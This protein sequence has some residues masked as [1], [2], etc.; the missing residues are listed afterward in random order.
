MI[1]NRTASE[2]VPQGKKA[3]PADPESVDPILIQIV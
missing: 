3:A 1:A 2:G